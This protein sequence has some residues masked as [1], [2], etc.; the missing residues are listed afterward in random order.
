[1]NCKFKE[2]VG[3]D[4]FTYPAWPGD[5]LVK[6][7]ED[8]PG[9][10]AFNCNGGILCCF[11]GGT[12]VERIVGAPRIN[13]ADYRLAPKGGG[14][15]ATTWEDK[16]HRLI[17]DLCAEIERMQSLEVFVVIE[18]YK[19]IIG[20]RFDREEATELA[21][22]K[23]GLSSDANFIEVWTAAGLKEKIEEGP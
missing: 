14:P 15:L 11:S 18:K 8:N 7:G 13:T 10:N 23:G 19:D 16:A 5:M 6:L 4:K 1:M 20:V 12:V 3:G 21:W 22:E 9:G 2:L 17:Y